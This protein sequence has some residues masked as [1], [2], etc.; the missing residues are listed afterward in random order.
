MERKYTTIDSL[1]ADYFKDPELPAKDRLAFQVDVEKYFRICHPEH[2][3]TLL[4]SH[5]HPDYN[6]LKKWTIEAL[7]TEWKENKFSK[8]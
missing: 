6:G 1:V 8:K 2:A 5:G 4:Q 7:Y 3:G